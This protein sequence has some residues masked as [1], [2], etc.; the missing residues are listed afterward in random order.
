MTAAARLPARSDPAKSQLLRPITSSRSSAHIGQELE[1]HYRWHPL[2]GRRVKIRDVEQR[3]GGRVV[4][5]EAKPGV[6][7][8]WRPWMLDHAVCSTMPLGDHLPAPLLLRKA[9]VC[10]LAN[11]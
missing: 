7:R 11:H 4:H 10:L 3:G 5:V 6:V 9:V 1:V 8:G 2:F